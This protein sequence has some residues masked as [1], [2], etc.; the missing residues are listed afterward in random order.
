[1]TRQLSVRH[2]KHI[3]F[4]TNKRYWPPREL[5]LSRATWYKICKAVCKM[6]KVISR[7]F[8][9]CKTWN[10]THAL[11]IRVIKKNG[12]SISAKIV[13]CTSIPMNTD[14]WMYLVKACRQTRG[15]CSNE[16]EEADILNI[17]DSFNNLT[18]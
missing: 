5:V 2:Q 14:D 1:M 11:R 8:K 6:N 16:T 12:H 9:C 4:I 13:G 18:L 3:T 7:L 10:V 17:I 15:R